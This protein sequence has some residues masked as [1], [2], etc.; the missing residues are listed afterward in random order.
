MTSASIAP[1][2]TVPQT[3]ATGTDPNRPAGRS[4]VRLGRRSA[5]HDRSP[6]SGRRSRR[7][8]PLPA[9]ENETWDQHEATAAP[10]IVPY[11]NRGGEH[12]EGDE[13]QDPRKPSQHGLVLAQSKQRS[14]AILMVMSSPQIGRLRSAV[15]FLPTGRG[16]RR[17]RPRK[18]T[19]SRNDQACFERESLRADPRCDRRDSAAAAGVATA[20]TGQ[21]ALQEAVADWIGVEVEQVTSGAGP[22]GSSSSCF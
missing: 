10:I 12:C 5:H 3:N 11:S 6:P 14:S 4:I 20:T 18:N 21:T 7:P 19:A 9:Q 2:R 8:Q 1:A 13:R 16:R 22:S 15:G 17:R